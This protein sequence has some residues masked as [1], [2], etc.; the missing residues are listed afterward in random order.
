MRTSISGSLAVVVSLA[1]LAAGPASGADLADRGK[2]YIYLTKTYR[3]GDSVL[4]PGRYL[5]EHAALGTEHFLVVRLDG[6]ESLGATRPP[7]PTATTRIP[8]ELA[9]AVTSPP[10]L[11]LSTRRGP[12][13]DWV[14]TRIEMPGESV[15]HVIP[16]RPVS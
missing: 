13:R 9:A 4:R 15:T 2:P 10:R 7:Y 16:P 5:F 1:V 14:I 8:C 12:D 6:P 3:I 11:Q